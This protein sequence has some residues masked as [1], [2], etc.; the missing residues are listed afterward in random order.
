MTANPRP[1]PLTEITMLGGHQIQVTQD[2][3]AV[4]AAIL[5]A[6]RG[7]LMELAW[8]TDATTNQPIGINPEHV[9]LL[10]ALTPQ[11]AAGA[12]GQRSE[13]QTPGRAA[14]QTASAFE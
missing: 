7:S 12:P 3:K 14:D 1:T 8:I 6:S 10:R 13:P 2:P 9:L 11:A 4:E 5:S